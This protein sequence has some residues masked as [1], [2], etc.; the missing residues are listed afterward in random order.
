MRRIT[1]DVANELSVKLEKKGEYEDAKVFKLAALE[2]RRRV[3]GEE[4]KKILASLN[5]LW[6]ILHSMKD[7]EE[8][9]ILTP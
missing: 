3:L 9:H 4:H 2:W 7:Y 8:A 6:G 5:N 1:H